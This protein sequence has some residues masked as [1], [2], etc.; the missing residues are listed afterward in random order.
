MVLSG[1]QVR[2]NYAAL[3]EA[4]DILNISDILN[5]IK[6][7]HKNHHKIV[8]FMLRLHHS[9]LNLS[10]SVGTLICVFGLW[11]NFST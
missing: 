7:M 3:Y 4:L 10:D 2:L 6:L 9:L 5:H 11:A 8:F 1:L